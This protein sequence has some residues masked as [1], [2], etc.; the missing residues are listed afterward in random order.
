M[1]PTAWRRRRRLRLWLMGLRTA[2][3]CLLFCHFRLLGC[4]VDARCL[5]PG[6]A[7]ARYA[8]EKSAM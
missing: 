6:R 2:F 1:A 8:S 4:L 7:E 5:R 3:G